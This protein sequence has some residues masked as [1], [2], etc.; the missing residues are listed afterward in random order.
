VRFAAVMACSFFEGQ[1]SGV[2][3]GFAGARSR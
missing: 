2:V 1:C 3:R